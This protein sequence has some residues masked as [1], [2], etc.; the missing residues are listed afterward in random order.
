MPP[1]LLRHDRHLGL[2]GATGVGVGAIVGGGIL[3]LAGVALATTGPA[4]ILAFGLNGLIALL[5]ALS[6][7]E[8]SSKFPESGGT[9]TFAKKVLSVEAA[10]TVGWVV[11][12]ASIMAAVLYALGFAYFSMVMVSDLWQA[13]SGASSSWLMH[14]RTVTGVAVAT[15]IILA[16]VLMRKAAGGGVWVNVGKVVVFAVLIAGGCWALTRASAA[17]VA[18]S[19]RPFFS[20]GFAGLIQAMGYTFIALQGFDLIAAVGGEV[21]NPERILPRAMVLALCIA[22]AIYLPLLF[23]IVTVGTPADQSIDEVAEANPESIVA[24]AARFYLGPFGYWLVIVA[25]ILSMLSALLANLFAASRIARAMARDRTLPARLAVLSAKYHTPYTAVLATSVIVIVI[26]LVLPDVAAA[27]AASSLIFLVTF[28]I[29]HGVAVLVRQRDPQH[30]PPF[31]TPLFPVVPIVGGL[32]CVALAVFQGVAIPAAGLI[33]A[34]WL[35]VGG[36]LFLSLFAHRARLRDASSAALDPN[37]VTL[38][39]RTPV[40]L[41]PIVNPQ[42]AQSLIALA[43]AL[44]PKKVGRVLTLTVIA[45]PDDWRPDQDPAPLVIATTLLAELFGASVTMG[46]R[47]TALTTVAPDPMD[48]IVRVANLHRCESVLLGLSEISR[49]EEGAPLERLFGLINADVVVLRAAKDWRLTEA[50]RILVP[51]AGRGGHEHLLAR[52]LGSLLRTGERE[53]TFL[54]VLPVSA[55]SN[56]VRRAR[57]ELRRLAEDG[58]LDS[59]DVEIVQCEDAVSAVADRAKES[60]LIILGVQR[61]GR[62][63]KLFGDFTRHIAARTTRP[64]I[65]MSR[66]G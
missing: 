9:Y 14:S 38:R 39:G 55:T 5:T 20:A 30:P 27:G 21:R 63:E 17:D 58:G 40:V 12:F 18:S 62:R 54:R 29:A 28:A 47:P 19:L 31:R 1:E 56:E 16:L 32:A 4:A 66:R 13:V 42:N 65:V 57:T 44:T 24:L 10:F 23:L 11:W 8:M 50:A 35:C 60:D 7:A 49:R 41:V 3:A 53:I 48:E 61:L 64:I 36:I 6:F 34:I 46:I 33:T 22:L 52:L 59:W 25:A 51:L 2:F 45:A 26:L 15:T 43:D 37:L